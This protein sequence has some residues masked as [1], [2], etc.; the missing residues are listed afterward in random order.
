MQELAVYA[1]HIDVY[2]RGAEILEKFLG[3]HPGVSTVYR[4]TNSYGKAIEEPLYSRT[5]A[6][7]VEDGEV[8]YAEVDGSM[9]ST[10]DGW[11]EV[12]L[13]RVFRSQDIG[14][15]KAQRRGQSVS[16]SLY[17]AHLGGH[18][19]FCAR[20][21]RLTDPYETLCD[22]LVF[23][24]DGARWIEKWITQKYPQATQILDFYHAAEHLAGL[25][26]AVFADVDDRQDWLDEQKTLL[27]EGKLEKLITLI[28]RVARDR[29]KTIRDKANGLINYYLENKARMA[30]DLYLE[31]GYYIGSGAIE[32]AHRTLVA[33]RLKLSGQR[34]TDPGAENVL[35]LRVCAMSG[36]WSL[37][38]DQIK[39]NYATAA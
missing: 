12:K 5:P 8:V 35:N 7:P 28:R 23:L 30:Y 9:I 3:V 24:S 6:L 22:R 20:L 26:E 16:Q 1:G 17:A 18:E 39:Q 19:T 25:A 14:D 27:L 21:Q 37:V 34:W 29:G 33:R 15:G 36:R 4:V 2:A 10:D 31:K 11:R 32:S 13:G 38:V